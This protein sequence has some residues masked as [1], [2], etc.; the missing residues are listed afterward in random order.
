MARRKRGPNT[1][2]AAMADFGMAE[3]LNLKRAGTYGGGVLRRLSMDF[4]LGSL[5]PN[6]IQSLARPAETI[7]CAAVR[8]GLSEGWSTC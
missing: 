7:S 5:S 6:A 2:K 4:L 1:A 3:S 8:E